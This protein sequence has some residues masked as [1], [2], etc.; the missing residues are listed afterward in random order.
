MNQMYCFIK[1][2]LRSCSRWFKIGLSIALLIYVCSW[3]ITMHLNTLQKQRN[4]VPQLPVISKDS[5]EFALLTNTLLDKKVFQQNGNVETV[6]SP[7]YPFFAAVITLVGR[8]FF[9]VTFVQ[10]ILIFLS[11]FIIRRIGCSVAS[12]NVGELSGLLFVFNPVTLVLAL[13]LM[14]DT[15][16]LF[17]FVLGFYI[18][19]SLSERNYWKYLVLVILLF[20]SAIYVRQMGIFALPIFIAPIFIAQISSKK[21]T[22]VILILTLSLVATTLPWTLRNYAHT[23]VASFS[24]FK[25]LNLSWAVTQFMADQNHTDVTTEVRN[26]EKITGIS[27]EGWRDLRNADV[28]SREAERIIL[29]SPFSYI[30]FH[31]LMSVSFLSSSPLMFAKEYYGSAMHTQE[32]FKIGAMHAFVRG[33]LTQFFK[34]LSANWM[35][36]VDRLWYLFVYIIAA[37]SLWVYKSKI[38]VWSCVVII[39]Y[40]MLL[41]GPAA[42]VRYAFQAFPFIFLLFSMSAWD[43]YNKIRFK[44][45]KSTNKSTLLN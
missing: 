24:S 23:S 42:N 10:I 20:S 7:G 8:S 6:R 17:L 13:V 45:A 1:E 36:T 31:T 15:L 4:I 12:R 2:E 16:F 18:A 30:K 37:R 33:E 9:A 5:E 19:L 21:R 35:K 22:Q 3:G 27:E 26:F 11:V 25:S 29:R 40:L 39:G 44:S 32:P 43:L 14:T 38:A 34:A 28:V 41:S